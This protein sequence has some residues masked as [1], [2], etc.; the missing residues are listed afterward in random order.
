MDKLI[1]G[2]HGLA[3]KPEKDV[4]ES[5][6]ENSI[7]EGLQNIGS[8][9]TAINFKLVYWAGYLYKHPMHRDKDYDFD[10]LY[11][12]EP[13]IKALPDALVEH[14]DDWKDGMRKIVGQLLGKGADRLRR[15]FNV[16]G[17]SNRVLSSKLKDLDYYYDESK[18][19]KNK[20]GDLEEAKTV[21]QAELETLLEDNADKELMLI[22]HSMGSIIA[23]DVLRNMGKKGTAV[24]VQDFVT[25]GSPLGLPYVK[26]K[27]VEE[28]TRRNF[29]DAEQV[30]TPTI[31]TRSWINYADPLDPVSLDQHLE[32]DYNSND[33]GVKVKDDI[34]ENDYVGED[35]ERNHHKSYG[36]LRTPELSKLIDSFL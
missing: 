24:R 18:R 22:S 35:G 16:E 2:I 10:A 31:V 34:V 33:R 11:N 21:L 30:R 9:H 17:I 5:W 7:L 23:Y 36:Y 8:S 3:N 12:S 26:N 6:W 20:S 14:D 32:D 4:L 29:P 15:T 1:I 19:V 13:Y 25:I 27:V 28:R